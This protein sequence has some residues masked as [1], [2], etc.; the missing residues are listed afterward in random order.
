MWTS[1]KVPCTTT[2]PN[3][4]EIP[5]DTAAKTPQPSRDRQGVEAPPKRGA[6]SRTVHGTCT[7]VL[8]LHGRAPR[9]DVMGL[10]GRMGP[11]NEGG[12]Q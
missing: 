5:P 4:N 9:E 12:G 8:H 10:M 2:P 3:R 11:M 6:G 1:A 7:V